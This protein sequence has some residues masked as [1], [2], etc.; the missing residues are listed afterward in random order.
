MERPRPASAARDG[1]DAGGGLDPRYADSLEPF[2]SELAVQGLR[3]SAVSERLVVGTERK[4]GDLMQRDLH[5]LELVALMID[6]VHFADHVVLAA[7]GINP[8]GEQ[9][10]SDRAKERPK[11]R[12]RARRCS[13]I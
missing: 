5:R 12:P 1:T 8:S 11:T 3:K 7:T 2:P 4:L 13:R 10:R 9:L 6:G